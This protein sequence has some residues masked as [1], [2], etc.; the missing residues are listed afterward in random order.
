MNI[1]FYEYKHVQLWTFLHLRVK[2]APCFKIVASTVTFE[3]LTRLQSIVHHRIYPLF[4]FDIDLVV[5]VTQTIFQY[6]LHH[7]A[8]AQANF[9]IATPNSYGADAF[10]R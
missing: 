10:T 3:Y 6:P 7:V 9:E 1:L 2:E 5:K 8:Y 4:I